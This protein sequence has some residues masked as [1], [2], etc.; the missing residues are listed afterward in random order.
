MAQ[1]VVDISDNWEYQLKPNFQSKILTNLIYSVDVPA[2]ETLTLRKSLDIEMKNAALLIKTNHQTIRLYLNGK[3]I[4]ASS[5]NDPSKNPGMAL[6]FVPLPGDY[7]G[8]ILTMEIVSPYSHYSGRTTPV[9]L[10]DIQSLEAYTLSQS[11]RSVIFMAICLFIGI[12]TIALTILQAMRNHVNWG[13]F[14]IG[15]FA[16]VWGLYYLCT[17]YIAYQFFSPLWMSILSIGFYFAMQAPLSLFFY[18]SY[19]HYRKY[20]LPAVFVHCGFVAA[21]YWLQAFEIKQFTQL[22]NI[23]NTIYT[24]GFFYIILLSILEIR[25]GNRFFWLVTPFM[26]IAYIS[27][28]KAFIVFYGSKG[29][30]NYNIYKDTFF[31]FILVVLLY[32]IVQFFHQHYEKQR[33]VSMLTLQNRLAA[34]NYEQIKTHL[35]QVAGLK[36][37]MK[38]HFAALQ[39]LLNDEQ[40]GKCLDYLTALTKQAKRL[41]SVSYCDNLL[42]NAVV[43][44]FLNTAKAKNITVDLKLNVSKQINV[45]DT[46]LYSLLTNMLENALEASEKMQEADQRVIKLDIHIKVP[47]LYIACQNTKSHEII[48]E[49]NKIITTKDD[50]RNHGYG[51]W[52]IRQI[53]EKYEGMVNIEYHE[54]DFK[55]MVALK[56]QID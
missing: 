40:Y 56:D 24:V 25:K 36:H 9:F 45:N 43:G 28:M 16:I 12:C 13:N 14:A 4:F 35:T 55:I 10:G 31:L 11:M 8:K 22:L 19:R 7:T 29:P 18:F 47:Y 1:N 42:V 27:L 52:T 2:G 26:V 20:F 3:E 39:I 46:D 6:F 15:V 5:N 32:N 53:T 54:R 37:E 41:S 38:N 17:D 50:A 51:I 48:V 21:A 33:E 30:V 44:K 34:E 23:N 49:K